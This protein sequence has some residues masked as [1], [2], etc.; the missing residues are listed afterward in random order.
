M[1]Q[2]FNMVSERSDVLWESLDALSLDKDLRTKWMNL[3]GPNWELEA[4]I[5]VL[6]R[7]VTF[8]VK[9]KQQI[10]REKEG[11]KPNKNSV[12]LKTP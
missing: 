4:S 11:L 8:F 7:I 10:I 1:H 3:I 12:S 5:I 9:S 2:W 6:Q